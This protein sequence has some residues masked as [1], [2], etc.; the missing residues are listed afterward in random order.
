MELAIGPSPHTVALRSHLHIIFFENRSIYTYIFPPI[1]S[2]LIEILC[3]YHVVNK[4]YEALH[5]AVFLR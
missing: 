5:Y 3:C 4:S 2:S 1:S